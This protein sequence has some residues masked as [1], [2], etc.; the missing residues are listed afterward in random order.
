MCN[1]YG[2]WTS[3]TAQLV[4]N[5]PAIQ[6]TWVRFLGREDPLKKE[7]NG[8]PLQYSGLEN[9]MDCNSMGL[10]RIT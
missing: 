9:S 5:L 1:I 2:Y 4:R 7:G 8:Y 3:L 6:E 10:Q